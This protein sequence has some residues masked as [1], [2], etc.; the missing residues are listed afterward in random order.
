MEA[1]PHRVHADFLRQLVDERLLREADLRLAETAEGAAG[2]LVG[3]RGVSLYVDI[4]YLI[5]PGGVH[6]AAP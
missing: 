5:R 3:G 1:E 6:G 2:H 4:G